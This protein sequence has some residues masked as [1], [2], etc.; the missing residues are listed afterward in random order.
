MVKELAKRNENEVLWEYLGVLAYDAIHDKRMKISELERELEDK[1]DRLQW[2]TAILS[3]IR[4]PVDL[5]RFV[6]EELGG[7]EGIK[8]GWRD[9]T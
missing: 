5:L 4:G 9:L 1:E 8:G 7:F 2:A 3:S 6:G